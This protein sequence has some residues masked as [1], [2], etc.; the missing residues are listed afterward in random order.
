MIYGKNNS[1]PLNGY[2][3]AVNEV[4]GR[5]AIANP[6]LLSNRGNDVHKLHIF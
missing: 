2:Q 6:Q 5:L 4:A 1:K 3:K